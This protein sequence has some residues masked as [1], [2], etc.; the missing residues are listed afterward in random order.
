MTLSR[1]PRRVALIAVI[2]VTATAAYAQPRSAPGGFATVEKTSAKLGLFL[3]A[4]APARRI[5]LGPPAANEA[6]TFAK[7]EIQSRRNRPLRIGFEREPGETDR[8]I[9]LAALPW[10]T[11][12]D[13]GLGA[14]LVVT[15]DTAAGIRLNLEFTGE[16]DL[17]ARLM[18]SAVGAEVF[19]AGS[20]ELK[21]NG[22][23]WSPVLDGATATVD[24]RVPPGSTP[25]GYLIVH[26]VSHVLVA[27]TELKLLSD[28]GTSG[29]CEHDVACSWSPATQHAASSV[30][31]TVLEDQGFV[32]L[33]TGTLLNSTPQTNVPYLMT[34]YHCYDED[35]VRTAE[36]VQAVANS[37]TTYWFFDATAC[38]SGLPAAYKQVGGGATLLYRAVDLDFILLQMR[39][40]APA[41]A[42]FSA[43]DANPL[44]SG[45]QAIVI[46]HPQG[47]LKKLSSGSTQGYAPADGRGSFIEMLYAYG[48]TEAGSS[49]SPLL[50]CEGAG[51]EC[52]GYAVRGALWGGAAACGDPAGIDAY[53]RL[54]LAYPYIA[55]FLAPNAVLPTGPGVAVEFYNVDLDHFFVTADG[56]E[57]IGV[58]GGSAGPGWFRTGYAFN[59]LAPNNAVGLPVCRFYGSVSP[60][61]NSHFYT[62]DAGEC[63]YLKD[64]QAV[65]PPT[66]PR[67]NFENIAFW[68]RPPTNSASCPTGT[69]PVYRYYNNGFPTRDS[70]HRLV[71]SLDPD[72]FMIDQGW[73]FEGVAMCSAN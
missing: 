59:T 69:T 37:L 5:R 65:Q 67:W 3:S 20:E 58:D 68:S 46:H 13:G 29:A 42:W 33:C 52:A 49:G 40:D 23:A 57:Q 17:D 31:Q 60:G 8:T 22:G 2:V 4:D 73:R 30:V 41:G 6:G 54:D 1:F 9:R 32:V 63:Q 47:D 34:A 16:T 35:R 28:V 14:R 24:L 50:T 45:T 25:D 72:A 27:A 56:T 64:L 36:D 62:L 21:R 51:S 66:Q 12:A 38:G 55:K 43:W 61:P 7:S 15:S 39:N 48:S 44:P 10:Q 19:A 26:R 11:L 53:S 71:P 18:G 70:N